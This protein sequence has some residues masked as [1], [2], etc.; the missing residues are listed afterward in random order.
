MNAGA[1]NHQAFNSDGFN[2]E[3]RSSIISVTNNNNYNTNHQTDFN[4]PKTA[5]AT[6]NNNA[7][8]NLS[9]SYFGGFFNT[10]MSFKKQI[11]L[12]K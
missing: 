7:N 8:A 5:F 3:K 1:Q 9:D 4:R 10:Q 12:Q 11:D 2:R 6:Q